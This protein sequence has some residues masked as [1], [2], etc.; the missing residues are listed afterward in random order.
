MAKQ[1]KDLSS[2]QVAKFNARCAQLGVDPSKIQGSVTTAGAE[3]GLHCGHPGANSTFPPANILKL[4][5]VAQLKALSACNDEDY[6]R[7]LESDAHVKYPQP[8]ADLELP[9]LSSYGS[10][11]TLIEN[12]MTEA[13]KETVVQ[14]LHAYLV[15]NSNKVKDYEPIINAI[16]FPM[17]LAVYAA[18]DITITA[19]N[20]LVLNSD[21]IG[22]YN[23]GVVTVEPGGSIQVLTAAQ[24]DSQVFNGQTAMRANADGT[25]TASV[26]PTINFKGA[27]GSNGT[28]GT[29]GTNGGNGGN[30][31]QG[32]P[33]SN[34]CDCNNPSPVAA[35]ASGNGTAGSSG[36]RGADGSI[37]GNS[38]FSLGAISGPIQVTYVGGV[39][40]NGGAGMAG[41]SGGNGGNAAGAAAS[42]CN[43]SYAGTP[44]G[45]GANGG[46]G[47]NGGNG[48]NG[49]NVTIY[50]TS[51][52]SD[53]TFSIDTSSIAAG[54]GGAA[55]AGGAAGTGGTGGGTAG[56]PGTAGAPGITGS[57]GTLTTR[58]QPA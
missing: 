42:P 36:T 37:S 58:L 30:A 24:M 1:F 16:H 51:I 6:V 48:A 5:N 26:V 43:N 29:A 40:G 4:D 10:D 49:P 11:L 35:T 19:A 15:G 9:L 53:T 54:S 50:Y 27:N 46:N 44:S 17:S 14:A 57:P 45:N 20:P 55:G 25:A 34:N 7:G 47:G 31:K 32:S 22:L 2:E 13:Q 18:Q 38:V 52:T 39:G 56:T 21:Q 41:G 33:S 28:D 3:G 8:V 12:F 23:F